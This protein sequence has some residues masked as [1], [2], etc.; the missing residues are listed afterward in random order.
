MPKPADIW[1]NNMVVPLA[2]PAA[3]H[4]QLAPCS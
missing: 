2:G 1:I 3:S 4:H